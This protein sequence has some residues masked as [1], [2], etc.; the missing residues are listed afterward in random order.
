MAIADDAGD[1]GDDDDGGGLSLI[2][3]LLLSDLDLGRDDV[4]SCGRTIVIPVAALRGEVAL[5]GVVIV[6]AVVVTRLVVVL[7]EAGDD[8]DDDDSVDSER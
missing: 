7:I 8:D 5:D 3:V 2:G 6:V 4:C 1:A